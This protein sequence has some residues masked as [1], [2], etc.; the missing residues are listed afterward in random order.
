MVNVRKG[1]PEGFQGCVLVGWENPWEFICSEETGWEE[2][3]NQ[4]WPRSLE[5]GGGTSTLSANL[6]RVPRGR[7][8]DAASSLN[9]LSIKLD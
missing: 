2:T 3:G 1:T 7:G 5:A 8:T 6:L 9:F 4:V